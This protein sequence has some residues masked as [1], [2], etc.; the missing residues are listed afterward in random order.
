MPNQVDSVSSEINA[1]F[2]A[3]SR[4]DYIK[5]E[6]DTDYHMFWCPGRKI[7][8]AGNRLPAVLTRGSYG[9]PDPTQEGKGKDGGDKMV[10]FNTPKA[11]DPNAYCYAMDVL[12]PK[13]KSSPDPLRRKQADRLKGGFGGGPYL[14]TFIQVIIVNDAM[15]VGICMLTQGIGKRVHNADTSWMKDTGYHICDYQGGTPFGFRKVETDK[16]IR[17]FQLPYNG[18]EGPQGVRLLNETYGI[19]IKPILDASGMS[20]KDIT[21]QLVDLRKIKDVQYPSEKWLDDHLAPFLGVSTGVQ[22]QNPLAGMD[23]GSVE[24]VLDETPAA[25]AAPAASTVVEETLVEETVEAPAA[26]PAAQPAVAAAAQTTAQAPT[27]VTEEPLVEE[28]VAEAPV[29]APPE[30]LPEE[31]APVAPG[32]QAQA[33]AQPA[34]AAQAA[35]AAGAGLSEDEELDRLLNEE[36]GKTD[37][38]SA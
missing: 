2:A 31:A 37:A 26:A 27:V 22:I 11:I 4:G 30:E 20:L 6:N 38:A 34:A 3:H 32:A 28:T 25:S 8:E 17:Y 21:N 33:A 15:K 24:N 12:I 23:S 13:A 14:K 18:H 36:L 35:P 9:F 16:G 19:G 7:D 10:Y 1:A 5:V 29:A